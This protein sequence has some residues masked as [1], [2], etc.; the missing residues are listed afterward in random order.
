VATGMLLDWDGVGQEQYDAIHGSLGLDDKPADGLLLHTAGPKPGGWR[1]F[2]V[3]E[4]KEA[5]DRFVQDRLM[6]A[7][8]E[9]GV[10]DR[11]QPQLYEVYNVYSPGAEEIARVGASAMPGAGTE[12]IPQY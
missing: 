11:P 4:S 10:A 6:P 5:F 9:A 2:D 12:R 1:V 7:A 3:W 8:Q